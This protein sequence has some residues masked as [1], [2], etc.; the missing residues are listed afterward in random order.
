MDYK[1]KFGFGC[2]RLPQTDENDPTKIDQE[3][4]N[5]KMPTWALT[6]EEDNDKFVNTMLERLGIDYFDVFLCIISMFHG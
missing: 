5:D 4:F 3:L 2:M 1:S 6:S